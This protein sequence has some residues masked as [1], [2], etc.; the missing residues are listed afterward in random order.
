[1]IQ[2]DANN[3]SLVEGIFH[4]HGVSVQL[5]PGKL[6]MDETEWSKFCY[7]SAAIF[8]S[9]GRHTS[10]IPP[11]SNSPK[12]K[13]KRPILWKQ[14]FAQYTRSR[15][16]KTAIVWVIAL[17]AFLGLFLYVS[18]SDREIPTFVLT[19]M[20]CV[21]ALLALAFLALFLSALWRRGSAWI[22]IFL[23]L[24]LF[25][26]IVEKNSDGV[27]QTQINNEK[28]ALERAMA[29]A[30]SGRASEMTFE[31]ADAFRRKQETDAAEHRKK[32]QG[33]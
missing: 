11:Q 15:S 23:T 1:M 12:V 21:L 14:L 32:I 30:T 22:I 8:K 29:K 4:R 13:P 16:E 18:N 19:G 33:R 24:L 31:E 10:I 7:N 25:G 17:A 20:L 6:T 3:C 9:L 27:A 2:D 5:S 26:L 28:R